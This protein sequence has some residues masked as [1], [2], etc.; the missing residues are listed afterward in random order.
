M[1]EKLLDG[2]QVRSRLEQMR[3]ERVPQSVGRDLR[4]ESGGAQTALQQPRH[5]PRRQPAAPR[6]DEERLTDLELSSAALPPPPR[7]LGKVRRERLTGLLAERR[8]PLLVPLSDDPREPRCEVDVFEVE[9]GR[10]GD[11]QTGRVEELEESAVAL[12]ERSVLV[13][14]EKALRVGQR[15][16]PGKRSRE[17][18]RR[19]RPCRVL[20]EVALA[21]RPPEG[22]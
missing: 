17:A 21:A 4:G 20:L 7:T 19:E 10:F 2:A 12:R 22:G 11:P 13:G 1:A 15:H 8:D 9:T 3:G 5:R 14:G 6:V 18:R 16:S